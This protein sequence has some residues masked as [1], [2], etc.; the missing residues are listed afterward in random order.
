MTRGELRRLGEQGALTAEA[1]T[2]AL[3]RVAGRVAEDFAQLPLTTGQ[4]ITLLRN[5]LFP[6]S[7]NHQALHS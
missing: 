7:S 2:T 4:A 1:V 5:Q 6:Q 3:E